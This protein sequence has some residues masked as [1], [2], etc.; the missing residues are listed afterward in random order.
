MKVKDILDVICK[1][2]GVTSFKDIPLKRVK[3]FQ[4]IDLGKQIEFIEDKDYKKFYDELQSIF[5][6][7]VNRPTARKILNNAYVLS[8]KKLN[9]SNTQ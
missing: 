2:E 3:E 8:L 6:S 9:D 4:E 7:R 1:A 5:E